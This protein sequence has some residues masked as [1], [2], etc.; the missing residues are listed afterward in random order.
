VAGWPLYKLLKKGVDG[1]LWRVLRDMFAKTSS[2]VRERSAD[3]FPLPRSGQGTPSTLLLTSTYDLLDCSHECATE[4][5]VALGEGADRG[6][7]Y[8]DDVAAVSFT[9]RPATAY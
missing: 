1:K 7:A 3:A 8:A 9:R 4:D 6:P 5:A 2:R